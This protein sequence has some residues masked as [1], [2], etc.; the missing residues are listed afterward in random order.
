MRCRTL[1]AALCFHLLALSI[2]CSDARPGLAPVSG[3]VTYAD[4]SVPT[5]E[6]ATIRFEPAGDLNAKNV[7]PASGTIQ[8]DGTFNLMTHKPDDGALVG[9]Y[10]VTFVIYK[11]YKGRE[12]VLAK[13]FTDRATTPHSATVKPGKN[14]FEFSVGKL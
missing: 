11:T 9:D 5:G 1:F 4:G 13:M 8:P 7:Q 12:P 3:K 2:G 14:Y 6:V 10:K